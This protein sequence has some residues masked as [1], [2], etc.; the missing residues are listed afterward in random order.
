M[1]CHSFLQDIL[2]TQGSNLGLLHCKQILCHLSHG[3]AL[4]EYLWV[5]EIL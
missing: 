1:G 4:Y 5:N 2:L 3:E